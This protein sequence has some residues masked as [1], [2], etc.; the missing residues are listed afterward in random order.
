MYSYEILISKYHT[1]P[2][3]RML[4]TNPAVYSILELIYILMP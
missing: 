2:V 1:K 3:L 4:E